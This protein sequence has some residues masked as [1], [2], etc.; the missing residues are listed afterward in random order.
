[1][2]AEKNLGLSNTCGGT[3]EEDTGKHL[4]QSLFNKDGG[5]RLTTLLKKTLTQ[6]F[7]CS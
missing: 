4:C 2:I 1:M 3:F 6:V 5:L 7:S